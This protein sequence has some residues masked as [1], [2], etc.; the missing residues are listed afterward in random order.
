MPPIEDI[1]DDTEI[2]DD[3][4]LSS[5]KE[6]IKEEKAPRLSIRESIEAARKEHTPKEDKKEH[7]EDDDNDKEVKASAD[8]TKEDDKTPEKNKDKEIEPKVAATTSKKFEAPKGWTADAKKHFDTLP[9]AVKESIAK[10]EN[11]ASDGFKQYGDKVKVLDTYENLVKTYVPDHQKFGVDGPGMVERT[12]QWFKAISNTDKTQAVNSLK[13]LAKSFRLEEELNKAYGI[14]Q[15]NV[16]PQATQTDVKTNAPA[17]NSELA[18]LKAKIESLENVHTQTAQQTVNQEVMNWAKDKPHFEKV[19]AAMRGLI[20][21]GLVEMK[22]G[23][24]DLD[25]AY[26]QACRR[27]PVIHQE[28]LD[29]ALA[30]REAEIEAKRKAKIEENANNVRRSRNA[31]ASLKPSAPTVITE[32]A[33]SKPKRLSIRE[34]IRS[35]V[36]EVRGT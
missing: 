11:E 27:D 24:P 28:M 14:T 35:A 30:D 33:N 7:K 12:F 29:K 16:Q 31:S 2:L 21:A 6:E 8:K 17:D 18:A 32:P 3:P 19:R 20:E 4:L 10:R 15:T 1:D 9:E 26:E 22:D 36:E 34:S 23:K 5:K 25:N 13:Q